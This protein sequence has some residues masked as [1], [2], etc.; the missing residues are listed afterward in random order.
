MDTSDPEITFDRHGVC[1]HCLRAERILK[2]VQWTAEESEAALAKVVGE[3]RRASGQREYDTV[4]GLSGGV[5][6]SYTALLAH[7]VG[8]RPLAVHFDNGWGSELA[9]ENIQ[10]VVE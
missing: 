10:R 1:S 6:S 7:K 3:I 8:L 4:I 9:V 5:D 2:S